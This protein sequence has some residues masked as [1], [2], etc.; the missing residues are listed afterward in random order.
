MEQTIKQFTDSEIDR[1]IG[2][3]FGSVVYRTRPV[4]H[5][6]EVRVAYAWLN[7]QNIIGRINCTVPR[8]MI[9]NWGGRKISNFAIEV[10][11]HLHPYLKL[12]VRCRTNIS[13]EFREPH[14]IRLQ[15]IATATDKLI[16]PIFSQERQYKGWE[17]TYY[18]EY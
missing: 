1:A 3:V 2:Y 13:R 8:V 6:D 5:F 11:I 9:E 4:D 7:A 12:D 17:S 15:G 10:A 16:H 18:E 14:K